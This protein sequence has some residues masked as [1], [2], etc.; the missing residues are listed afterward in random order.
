MRSSPC[1]TAGFRHGLWLVS[2]FFLVVSKPWLQDGYTQA[3]LPRRLHRTWH[4][5]LPSPARV[6]ARPCCIHALRRR[7]GQSPWP[8][9]NRAWFSF[10]QVP[11]DMVESW[12]MTYPACANA[13]STVV[14]NATSLVFADTRFRSPMRTADAFASAFGQPRASLSFPALFRGSCGRSRAHRAGGA[15]RTR[16]AWPA[17]TSARVG[18]DVA[19][20]TWRTW[21]REKGGR[22]GFVCVL[23]LPRGK[24]R[25]RGDH[26]DATWHGGGAGGGAGRW[27]RFKTR[28]NARL[29]CPE[30]HRIDDGRGNSSQGWNA[31]LVHVERERMVHRSTDPYHGWAPV[32]TPSHVRVR[33]LAEKWDPGRQTSTD[34]RIAGSTPAYPTLDSG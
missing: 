23:A 7:V 3:L 32:G 28:P 20:R 2:S 1:W 5:Q 19:T 33:A 8:R 26:V 27:G 25:S 16:A 31:H 17:A 14:A 13:V 10:L 29:G 9:P 4:Q 6:L 21:A 12:D 22:A 11:A 15:A 24:G 34:E 30:G 18:A